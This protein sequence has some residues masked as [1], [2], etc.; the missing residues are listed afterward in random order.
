M[1]RQKEITKLGPKLKAILHIVSVLGTYMMLFGI[2]YLTL[3]YTVGFIPGFSEVR[4]FE[5]VPLMPV[6][7]SMVSIFII[8]TFIKVSSPYK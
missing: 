4:L 5:N 2:I 3:Q 1:H 6:L 8:R 7:F